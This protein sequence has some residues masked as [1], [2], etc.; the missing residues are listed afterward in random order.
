[1]D[2]ISL[3][4]K[5]RPASLNETSLPLHGTQRARGSAKYHSRLWVAAAAMKWHGGYT[6]LRLT[7]QSNLTL[8]E[9]SHLRRLLAGIVTAGAFSTSL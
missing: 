1:M 2:R 8:L 4:K 5:Y 7:H 9:K 3:I 6:S